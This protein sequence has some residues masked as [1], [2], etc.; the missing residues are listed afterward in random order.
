MFQAVKIM[1]L[2]QV[3]L[4]PQKSTRSTYLLVTSLQL[5]N[6]TRIGR[7]TS[8][9]AWCFHGFSIPGACETQGQEK[10]A[11]RD[12]GE[13]VGEDLEKDGLEIPRVVDT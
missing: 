12:E 9:T 1:G 3:Q 8:G 11:V 6:R 5:K 4:V 2:V 13:H 7:T 10:E